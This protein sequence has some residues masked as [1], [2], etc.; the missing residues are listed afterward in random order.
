MK[1]EARSTSCVLAC[2]AEIS[3]SVGSATG[4]Q[5]GEPRGYEDAVA[6]APAVPGRVAGARVRAVEEASS[7]SL[8]R[9]HS[10]VTTAAAELL[11]VLDGAGAVAAEELRYFPTESELMSI[12]S[13]SAVRGRY[14]AALEAVDIARGKQTEEHARTGKEKA[15]GREGN[16][17]S[18]AVL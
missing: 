17:L 10:E 7:V 8:P 5:S 13:R 9:E 3:S 1:A 6:A 18:L 11:V 16:A 14:E 12:V 4:G 15:Q 2:A